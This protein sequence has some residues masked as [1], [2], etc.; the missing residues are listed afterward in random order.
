MTPSEKIN[1]ILAF[2][3]EVQAGQRDPATVLALLEERL[4]HLGQLREDFDQRAS[5]RGEG[6]LHRHQDLI[7]DVF[8]RFDFYENAL[9]QHIQALQR[10]S[11]DDIAHAKDKLVEATAPL[12]EVMQRYATA[13][14]NHGESAYPLVNAVRL[15]LRAVVRGEAPPGALEELCQ[16]AQA[17]FQTALAE[18]AQPAL[19][20]REGYL[21]KREA[22]AHLI[23]SLQAL[24]EAAPHLPGEESISAWV[25]RLEE[26]FARILRSDQTIFQ[27]DF[28]Q[29]ST[30][31]PAANVLLN[32]AR[33][34]LQGTYTAQDVMTTLDAYEDFLEALETRFSEATQQ[35]TT[36]VVVLEE[37]PKTRDILDQHEE[38]LDQIRELLQEEQTT[39]LEECLQS[40]E[41][42]I[43]R[44]YD[45]SQVYLE[46]AE[47]EGKQT[48][49]RCGASNSPENRF[50]QLCGRSMPRLM[51]SS[52]SQFSLNDLANDGEDVI[53]TTEIYRLFEAC[54][55]F[56]EK[57]LGSEEFLAL[58][59]ASR[60][61][62][63]QARLQFQQTKDPQ[64]TLEEEESASA[65]EREDYEINLGLYH[66]TLQLMEEGLDEWEQ[67]LDLLEEFAQTRHR[68]TLEAGIQWV[69]SGSQKIVRV[70]EVGQTAERALAEGAAPVL[71]PGDEGQEPQ[72]SGLA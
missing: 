52:N 11:S 46:V 54:Y 47:R 61:K 3:A 67:G 2:S 13:Y 26:G 45:S 22:F 16:S 68:P 24:V 15:A 38:V 40:L 59:E 48:C 28:G 21:Q 53:I 58:V 72:D 63:T 42:L 7:E 43:E 10:G 69:F 6:F 32:V 25:E 70:Q 51:E 17:H 34:H 65:Q 36:S 39:G 35:E 50:C 29:G 71:R 12:M 33:A 30:P 60:R 18:T 44:L 20:E 64:P 9:E 5:E 23:E 4:T 57:R 37:L 1:E 56:Y 8:Q 27:E 19:L 62:V 41:G 31:M 66:E 55:G 49:M 14:H